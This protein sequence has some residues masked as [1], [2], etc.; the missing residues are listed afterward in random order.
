MSVAN[1]QDGSALA[2]SLCLTSRLPSSKG[3]GSQAAQNR[4]NTALGRRAA[5]SC[6][7]PAPGPPGRGS[8]HLVGLEAPLAICWKGGRGDEP[9]PPEAPC[10]PQRAPRGSPA[11]ED[12]R[13]CTCIHDLTATL[14]FTIFF[15]SLSFDAASKSL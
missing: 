6:R 15:L 11:C 4:H 3:P 10:I 8:R 14:E 13:S 1:L 12:E 7:R 2:G 9:G 5:P